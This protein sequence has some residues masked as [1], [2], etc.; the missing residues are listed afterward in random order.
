MPEGGSG[1]SAGT[2]FELRGRLGESEEV[3]WLAL[4]EE[5]G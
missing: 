2:G 4:V 3:V 5:R 1:R